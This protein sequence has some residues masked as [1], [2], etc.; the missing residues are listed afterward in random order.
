VNV[1]RAAPAETVDRD[2]RSHAEWGGGLGVADHVAREAELR[3][4]PWAARTHTMWIGQVAGE[5]VA[6]C[7]TYAMD[8]TAAGAPGTTYAFASVFTEA[9]LRGR[10]H[11]SAL[12]AA[13]MA[14]LGAGPGTQAFLLFSDVGEAIYARLGFVAL[15]AW[16]RVDMP[17]AAAAD[18]AVRPL[19]AAELPHAWP[20]ARSARPSATEE[21]PPFALHL[22]PEQLGWHL[23]E[24]ALSARLAG[25]PDLPTCGAQLDGAGLVWALDTRESELLV[26]EA[27][28]GEPELARLWARARGVAAEAGLRGVRAWEAVRGGRWPAAL[29]A[30]VPREGHMPMIRLLRPFSPVALPPLPRGLWV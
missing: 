14:E 25:L 21:L 11:A 20:P 29:G 8:S 13:V 1:R 5:D 24:A 2:R 19:H 7:E 17:A 10:G 18:P 12:L 26:L 22:P 30:R 4:G 15:S 6:S 9:H 3:C 16:D 27:V 23:H 28:G